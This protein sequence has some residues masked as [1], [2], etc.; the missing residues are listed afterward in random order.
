LPPASIVHLINRTVPGR[1]L[2]KKIAILGGKGFLAL[3]PKFIY[4]T[5]L[6]GC[7]V[8]VKH[9]IKAKKSIDTGLIA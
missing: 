5:I 7:P 9:E 8:E 1:N 3:S 6:L 2:Q 4:K